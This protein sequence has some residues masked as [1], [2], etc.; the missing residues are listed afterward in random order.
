MFPTKN[1]TINRWAAFLSVFF[2]VIFA[3]IWGRFVYLA[4][5]KTVSGH[6]MLEMGKKQWTTVKLV[7]AQRGEILGRDGAIFAHDVPAYTVYAV[8][9]HN[10]PSYVKDKEKTAQEL[11]SI[12]NVNEMTLLNY[13]DSKNY[14][15]QF[16]TAGARI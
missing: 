5:G 3:S 16:G 13:L 10:A 14:Q 4:E 8:L 12:L 15:V 2:L 1:K 7:D 9:S 6:N 11:S